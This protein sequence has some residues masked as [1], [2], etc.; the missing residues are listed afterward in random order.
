M[1]IQHAFPHLSSFILT[2]PHVK[3]QLHKRSWW[4]SFLSK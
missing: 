2:K 1:L 3:Y 4:S